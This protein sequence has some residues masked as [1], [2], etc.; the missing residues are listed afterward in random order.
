MALLVALVGLTTFAVPLIGTDPPVLGHGYWSPLAIVEQTQAG[1]LPLSGPTDTVTAAD[2]TLRYEDMLCGF[3]F[4]YCMLAA[5]FLAIVVGASVRAIRWTAVLCV[6]ATL[7]D[8]AFGHE[9][10]QSALC[11][12]GDGVQVHAGTESAILLGVAGLLLLIAS[13]DELD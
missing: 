8:L 1:V 7:A 6:I 4:A 5:A 13:F 2:L 9:A 10:Y 3:L 12:G 11:V